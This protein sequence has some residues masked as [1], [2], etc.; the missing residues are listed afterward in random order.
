M[1]FLQ[2]PVPLWAPLL[3]DVIV[4]LTIFGFLTQGIRRGLI[5][6]VITTLILIVAIVGSFAVSYVEPFI[7]AFPFRFLLTT[8]LPLF[9]YFLLFFGIKSLLKVQLD[10]LDARDVPL[11]DA[12]LGGILGLGRGLAVI[13]LFGLALALPFELQG[14]RLL[15]HPPF[16]WKAMEPIHQPASKPI[17]Q[18]LA[19]KL[20]S[21]QA[22]QGQAD[23]LATL[24]NQLL[25][26]QALQAIFGDLGKSTIENAA[27]RKEQR[28]AADEVL[29]N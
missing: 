23:E 29:G 3:V 12:L 16:T 11:W 14:K 19:A 9:V 22:A 8:L 28:S 1:A 7:P 15:P 18:W 24:I 5:E 6:L 2:G 27:K 10:K 20:Q 25:G 13:V 17:K 4:A 21:A 26:D